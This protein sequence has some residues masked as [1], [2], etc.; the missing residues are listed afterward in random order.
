L[1]GISAGVMG[2]LLYFSKA[3]G[4]VFFLVHLT[5]LCLKKYTDAR[6]RAYRKNILKNYSLALLC[7]LFVSGWWV[8]MLSVKYHRLTI[9]ENESFNLSRE[10]ARQSGETVHFPILSGGLTSP[11]NPTAVNAWED[12]GLVFHLEALQP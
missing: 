12:P 2:S 3:F 8:Y 7:F 11:P 5:V 4:F 6:D 9:S 1:F 10:V